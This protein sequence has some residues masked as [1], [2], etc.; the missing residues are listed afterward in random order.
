MQSRHDHKLVGRLRTALCW[1][2]HDSFRIAAGALTVTL[3]LAGAAWAV[4]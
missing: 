3:G 4:P 2:G 1:A